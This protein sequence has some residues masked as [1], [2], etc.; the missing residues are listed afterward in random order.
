MYHS[1]PSCKSFQ[2]Y[3]L[4]HKY[5][6]IF[7]IFVLNIRRYLECTYSFNWFESTL[8][9]LPRTQDLTLHTTN[10]HQK[11]FNSRNTPDTSKTKKIFDIV[12]STISYKD[13]QRCVSSQ[14]KNQCIFNLILRPHFTD[15]W[16]GLF[17]P[18]M[19][20]S[21]QK[22][23]RELETHPFTISH[24]NGAIFFW[25]TEAYKISCNCSSFSI[26]L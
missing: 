8:L 2:K 18:Q 26:Q 12:P 21:Q 4:V 7:Y 9:T 1:I 14:N 19:H 3:N 23:Y 16:T 5:F 17:W 25:K 13:T 20:L 22:I 11:L 24:S 10:K 6:Y 15:V